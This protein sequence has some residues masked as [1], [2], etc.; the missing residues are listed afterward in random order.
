MDNDYTK[1]RLL[2]MERQVLSGLKFDLSHCPPLHFLLI[3]ASIA[4][5]SDKVG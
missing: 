4:R 2:L 3:T 1:K 5:C